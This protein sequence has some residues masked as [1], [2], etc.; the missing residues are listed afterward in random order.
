MKNRPVIGQIKPESLRKEIK[1]AKQRVEIYS[2]TPPY[3]QLKTWGNI[4][5]NLVRRIP[6]PSE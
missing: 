4:L 2:Q 5:E 3:E 6:V 1:F